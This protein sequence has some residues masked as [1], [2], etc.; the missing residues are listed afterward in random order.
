MNIAQ[1]KALDALA[2]EKNFSKAGRLL[3]ISQPAIS[4]QLRNIQKAYGVKLFYRWGKFIEFTEFGQEMVIKARKVL[5]LLADMEESLRAE[6]TLQSGYLNLGLSC[7]Y[8]VMNPLATFMKRYPGV[9]VNAYVKDSAELMEDVAN[10][11]LDVAQVTTKVPDSRFYNYLYSRQPIILFISR[12]HPWAKETSIHVS[13]LHQGRM[14]ARHISSGTRRIFEKRLA[15]QG[16]APQVVLELDSW[17]GLK[18]A[19]ATGIG[20]GIALE[21]EFT[22]DERLIKLSLEGVDLITAQYFICLPEYKTLN[23]VSTLLDIVSDFKLNQ[24]PEQKD[25]PRMNQK[26]TA[27]EKHDYEKISE[28]V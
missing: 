13:Q 19:V 20:F 5:G 14:V 6:H 1:L 16:I 2:K 12:N 15:E 23:T 9:Q 10:C 8:L 24:T 25:R 18:E 11:R 21:D 7:H 22:P 17:A 28:P 4:L 27:K 26:K 3:G